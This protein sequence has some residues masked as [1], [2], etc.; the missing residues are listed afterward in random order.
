MRPEAPKIERVVKTQHDPL[1][2]TGHPLAE[3]TEAAEQHSV[4]QPV[5]DGNDIVNTGARQ[6]A[7]MLR[8]EQWPL[9]GYRRDRRMAKK[10]LRTPPINS[11]KVVLHWKPLYILG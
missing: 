3:E 5:T 1:E 10:E 2:H 11:K 9:D 7:R 4:M 8:H 6:E